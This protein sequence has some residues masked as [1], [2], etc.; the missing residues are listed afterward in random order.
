MVR[1]LKKNEC[2]KNSEGDG[3][4]NSNTDCDHDSKVSF[5]GDTDEDIDTTETEEDW[6]EHLKRSTRPAEEK[7]RTASVPCWIM[8]HEKMKWR[9]A[10][11]NTTQPETRWSKKQQN[12]IQVSAVAA[13]QAELWEDQERDGKTTSINSSSLRKQKKPRETI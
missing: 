5:M 4:F 10:M 12:G 1:K 9:L 2:S 3:G 11:R 13:R 8:T 7:M 6:I